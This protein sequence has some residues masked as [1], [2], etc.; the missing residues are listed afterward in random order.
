ML[1]MGPFMAFNAVFLPARI[2]AI[3]P[4]QKVSAIALIATTGVIVAT[5]ANVLFGALSDMTRTRFGRRVPWMIVG[6]VGATLGLLIVANAGSVPLIVTGWCLFQ[7]F[8]NAIIAPLIAILPDRVPTA[9]RGTMSAL[10]GVGLLLGIALIGQVAAPQFLDDTKTGMHIFAFFALLAGPLVAVITPEPSNRDEPRE[11]FSAKGLVKA[12]VFPMHE[13]RDYYFVFFGRLF[14]IIGTYVVVGYQLYILTDYLGATIAEAGKTMS[15]L[16]LAQLVG[17]VIV[18][19]AVGPIS[20][21]FNRRKVFIVGATILCTGG[22]LFLFF[23]QQPWAMIVFGLCSAIGG[24]IYNSVEQVVSTEVLPGADTA[25][26]DLGFLNVAGTGGQAIA[27]GVT[28]AAIATTGSFAPAFLV[29]G[30]FLVA[31]AVLFGRLRKTR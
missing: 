26:K 20:D 18:G 30:G 7:L 21:R 17:S 12:F 29:A 5:V 11:P 8:L 6:S 9:R 4:D 27:P 31:S 19:T 3:A 28:S 23:V 24:G 16:G 10:Y 14:N 15:L 2:E 1:C 25:A 22:T 13:S